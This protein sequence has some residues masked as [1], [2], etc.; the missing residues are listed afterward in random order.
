MKLSS[1]TYLAFE[2]NAVLD[3]CPRLKLPFAEIHSAA[4][5]ARLVEYL[6]KRF[7]NKADLS[8]FLAHPDE[9]AVV[10]LA[11]ADAAG[12]LQDR[13]RRKTGAERNGL[14]LVIAIILEAIQRQFIPLR[15]A[16]R[17]PKLC[18]P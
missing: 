8:L 3:A 1:L 9:H 15:P 11:L 4:R 10:N 5:E 16:K 18:N 17:N 13:E 12:G 6:A 14:C 2:T 7:G